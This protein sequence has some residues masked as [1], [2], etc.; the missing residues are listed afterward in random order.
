M[1]LKC[2][3]NWSIYLLIINLIYPCI[4]LADPLHKYPEKNWEICNVSE[5]S[6]W[7]S[8]KLKEAKEYSKI[9]GSA[10]MVFI[11]DG[12]IV[13]SLGDVRYKFQTRSIR[14][15]FLNA[16]YGIHV[17]E[18]NIDLYKTLAD[19]NIDDIPTLSEEEKKARVIDLLKSRSG[20]YHAAAYETSS[21]RNYRPTR[22]SHSAGSYWYYN[23]WDFNTL[24]TI[25][26]QETN[27]KVFKEFYRCI[28]VPLQ[29]EHFQVT[30]GYYDIEKDHSIHPASPFRMSTLDMARFGLLYLHEGSWKG[31]Q[32]ISKE[33]IKKEKTSYSTGRQGHG[34]G[35]KWEIFKYGPLSNLGAYFSEGYRGH[36]IVVLPKANSVFVHRVNTDIP[37]GRVTQREL[38]TLLEGVLAA[39][40]TFGITQPAVINLNSNTNSI[41]EKIEKIKSA[42]Y[43]QNIVYKMPN[44]DISEKFLALLGRWE[45][46]WGKV[47]NSVLIIDSVSLG[48]ASL[49][50]SWGS[51]SPWKIK[52]GISYHKAR[53]KIA[54][55]RPMIEFHENNGKYS[56]YLNKDLETIEGYFRR[57]YVKMQKTANP[58]YNK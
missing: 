52:K 17:Y 46:D 28:S 50:Y 58:I 41:L 18:G 35:F 9:I 57:G 49:I 19:L 8:N 33:W 30:D 16:I 29:M 21:M 1:Y 54:D 53:I 42:P 36:W 27:T 31:K 38:E 4:L 45:G 37:H 51:Y 47:L 15:S 13:I 24:V 10:A 22:G 5:M 6:S 23:N 56:F 12:K 48:S 2:T 11:H 39:N 55:G 14:K 26:E 34:V 43:P 20:I 40:P 32:I 44:S 25:F 7:S 3:Q